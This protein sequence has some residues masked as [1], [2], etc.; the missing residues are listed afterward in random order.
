M[1]LAK[2]HN[3][4]VWDERVQQGLL[5]T[6]TAREDEFK[7]PLKAING[8]GWISGGLDGKQ[9]LC[10]AGGGGLQAPLYAAAGANVTVVDISPEMIEQDNQVARE[11][12]LELTALV[13]SMDD[14]SM[15]ANASFDLVSQPVSTCYV[16][17]LL[18]GYDEIARHLDRSEAACRQLISRAR[19][20]VKADY[21]RREVAPEEGER[22]TA[23]EVLKRPWIGG[24]GVDEEGQER[25]AML[26][27]VELNWFWASIPIT[28]ISLAM[29]ELVKGTMDYTMLL[30]IFGSSTLIA[31]LLLYLS[32]IHI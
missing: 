28:N 27:G 18:T 9:V 5:H 14:L 26:P 2:D 31:G 7:S 8:R 24:D 15:L 30:A 11:R 12:G 20:H 29:K 6:R 10:L 21:A 17:N 4:R 22:L 1:E 19:K 3:R 25:L 23:A 32:L 16:P 13:G